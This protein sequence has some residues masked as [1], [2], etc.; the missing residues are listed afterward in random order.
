MASEV[1]QYAQ[2]NRAPGQSVH[3]D[4]SAVAL[5]AWIITLLGGMFL[6]AIWLIEYDPAIQRAA[7]TRLPVPVISGHAA[8]AV[9]GLIVWVSYLV[10]GDDAFALVTLAILAIVVGL[11][12]TMALRWIKVYRS[13]PDPLVPPER[14]FPLSV[15]IGHGI[16][17]GTTVVLVLLTTLGIGGS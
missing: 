3:K 17:A 14:H 9:A 6:L 16:F 15:V 11:G 1:A 4:M 5:I 10:T 2:L 8:L 12:T 7:A 13:E